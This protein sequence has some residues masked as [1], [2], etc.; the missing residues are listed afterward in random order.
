MNEI[1]NVIGLSCIEWSN[2]FLPVPISKLH[3]NMQG[4]QYE[5]EVKKC[6]WVFDPIFFI[7]NQW[8]LLVATGLVFNFI[9][10]TWIPCLLNSLWLQLLKKVFLNASTHLYEGVCPSVGSWKEQGNP[11]DEQCLL[12]LLLLLFSLVLIL[13]SLGRTLFFI[14]TQFIRTSGWEFAKN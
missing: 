14:R 8:L 1:S 11:R 10:S 12:L 2:L 7:T 9:G 13:F 5:N 4:C 3:H 6:I